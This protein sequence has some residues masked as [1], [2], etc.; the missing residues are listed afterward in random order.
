V[1]SKP[2][3]PWKIF[4]KRIEREGV[5]ISRIEVCSD[6]VCQTLFG[7]VD[8]VRLPDPALFRPDT[9]AGWITLATSKWVPSER[10]ADAIGSIPSVH[11]L[12]LSEAVAIMAFGSP[13]APDGT[14]PLELRAKQ[15][16]AGRALCEECSELGIELFGT[17][18]RDAAP[19]ARI[20]LFYHGCLG[21]DPNSITPDPKKP[22][23]KAADLTQNDHVYHEWFNVRVETQAFVE[24][25]K[26]TV[27]TARLKESSR[28]HSHRR[29]NYPLWSIET[30]VCWIAFRDRDRL[31]TE[32]EKTTHLLRGTRQFNRNGE[33]MVESQPELRL[34]SALRSGRLIAT[35]N[36]ARLDAPFWER[37]RPRPGGLEPTQP[38]A[39][40]ER[41]TVLR[42]FPEQPPR[43][44]DEVI[45]FR[46]RKIARIKTRWRKTRR[47]I[48]I[49][50][51][52]D[53]VAGHRVFSTGRRVFSR[54]YRR[55]WVCQQLRASFS[56][57]EFRSGGKSCLMLLD[58]RTSIARL[59][60]EP[61]SR[62]LGEDG[63]EMVFETVKYLEL[64]WLPN[65]DCKLW[66][67]RQRLKWPD[68]FNVD[69]GEA[70]TQ[71]EGEAQ[72]QTEGA[73]TKSSRAGWKTE[74]LKRWSVRKPFILMTGGKR[75]SDR[76]PG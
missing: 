4:D 60:Y 6:D 53:W 63:E 62:H 44:R 39:R 18:T 49:A 74:K 29:F 32:A 76:R 58:A 41:D 75:R 21:S 51:V 30:A 56:A 35:D 69:R 61:V 42:D 25:L 7:K 71:A 70:Q 11:W 16:Q 28:Q 57:G 34:L 43:S 23:N 9:T 52:A 15:E 68:H 13:S 45:A 1:N 65:E 73:P 8:S 37:H 38:A 31:E 66:F 3:W 67:R 46:G 64:C 33:A 12:S 22:R 36:D 72:T 55:E 47:F 26:E 50:E 10:T 24:W 14:D 5:E 40:V 54:G 19:N 20:D 27:T 2:K 59:N 17:R 48:S